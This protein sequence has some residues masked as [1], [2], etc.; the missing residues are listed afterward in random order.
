MKDTSTKY[1]IRFQRD[2]KLPLHLAHGVW[3]GINQQAEIEMNFFSE[4][5]DLPDQVERLVMTDGTVV[6]EEVV[7]EDP[8]VRHMTRTVVARLVVSYETARSL[9]NWL[10]DQLDLLD[11]LEGTGEDPTAD[12]YSPLSKREQ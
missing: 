10:D 6:H 7:G 11:E 2:P 4:S 9:V 3:G 1:K 12:K 5:E 8:D